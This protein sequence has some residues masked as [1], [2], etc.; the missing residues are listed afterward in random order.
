MLVSVFP[1]CSLESTTLILYIVEEGS[2]SYTQEGHRRNLR[3]FCIELVSFSAFL[4]VQTFMN[5]FYILTYIITFTTCSEAFLDM[6]AFLC[7]L[8]SSDILSLL[9]FLYKWYKFWLY[10][11]SFILRIR[12]SL[13]QNV[14]T[15]SEVRQISDHWVRTLFLQWCGFF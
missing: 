11:P 4:F 2:A 7:R 10:S 5:V 14:S 8:G 6:F 3:F 13:P 1:C 9:I 15:S 12:H